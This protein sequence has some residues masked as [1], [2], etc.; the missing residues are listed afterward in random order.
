MRIVDDDPNTMVNTSGPFG[1]PEA[2]PEADSNVLTPA[3]TPTTPVSPKTPK[4]PGLKKKGG[5]ASKTAQKE[6]KSPSS[7]TKKAA[8]K[9]KERKAG[10]ERKVVTRKEEITTQTAGL[11]QLQQDYE[12]KTKPKPYKPE[13]MDNR[14][15]RFSEMEE[16]RKRKR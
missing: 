15:I 10:F 14:V 7:P 6:P 16:E 11:T 5:L 13:V 2:V 3:K 1:T 8:L 9:V 4:S 12:P